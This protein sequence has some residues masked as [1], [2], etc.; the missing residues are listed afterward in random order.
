MLSPA[1]VRR[2]RVPSL[3]VLEPRVLFSADPVG[4]SAGLAEPVAS[5]QAAELASVAPASAEGVARSRELAVVDARVPDAARLLADLAAQRDAG[6][7]IDV[8]VIDGDDDGLRRIGDALDGATAYDAV[9]LFGHGRDGAIELGG[10]TL[11]AALLFARA[12]EVAGWSAGLAAGADLLLWGCDTGAGDAGARLLDGLAALTGADVAAST[13]ATGGLAHGGDWTLEAVRGTVGATA[14]LGDAL[15]AGF[16]GLL[17]VAAPGTGSGDVQVNQTLAG[18]QSLPGSGG[19]RQVASSAAGVTVVTWVD[20]AAD[21]VMVR[22]FDATGVPLGPEQRVNTP[23]AEASSPAV[24][25]DGSGGFVV[26]WI[27]ETNH[28]VYARLFDADGNARGNEFRVD[29]GTP[30]DASMPSVAMNASGAFVVAWTRHT[31]TDG[32]DVVFQRFDASGGELGGMT[33]V[34]LARTGDQLAPAVAMRADGSFLVALTG[35]WGPGSEVL[36][37]TYAADGTSPMGFELFAGDGGGALAPANL[38]VAVDDAGRYVIVWDAANGSVRSAFGRL[39]VQ[40]GTH[41]SGLL[42]LDDTGPGTGSALRPAVASLPAGGFAVA[43]ETDDGSDGSGRTVRARAFL[44]GGAADGASQRVNTYVDDDQR[45]PSMAAVGRTLLVAWSG[46]SAGDS[47]GVVLR[48]FPGASTGIEVVRSGTTTDESGTTLAHFDVRLTA[49]PTGVVRLDLA[50]S[51][52][53]DST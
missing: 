22:R 1:R 41:A 32:R 47:E 35:P 39:V 13:D 29:S 11:D 18:T 21:N 16:A 20:D 6:R 48:A 26:V 10:T 7:P 30:D 31:S 15:R 19:G 36:Y 27:R 53:A 40:A 17:A 33:T 52:A 23:G 38:D 28:H 2:R 50:I 25:M 42:R 49:A 14:P 46:E 44:D 24:A 34:T 5:P 37:R 51:N 4:L 9:H 45:H 8:V 12:G 43:W 3:E